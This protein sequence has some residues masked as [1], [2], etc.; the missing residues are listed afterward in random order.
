MFL[1]YPCI[2]WDSAR[3]ENKQIKMQKQLT[4]IFGG[5]L[6][7]FSLLIVLRM[8]AFKSGKIHQ[9]L[10]NVKQKIKHLQQIKHFS[11]SSFELFCIFT[12]KKSPEN[13]ALGQI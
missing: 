8:P 9:K 12:G 2:L 6:Q 13:L 5:R 4:D 1:N 11:K 3:A 10:N 7:P